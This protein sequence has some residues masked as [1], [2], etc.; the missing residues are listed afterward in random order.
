ML[1]AFIRPVRGEFILAFVL[2][3]LAL[4]LGRFWAFDGG[5]W[6][7]T[8]LILSGLLFANAAKNWT[9]LHALD[10][11]ARRWFSGALT[12]AIIWSIVM[13]AI[14]SAAALIMQRNSPYY[15]WYD[16]FINTEG[17]VKHVDTNGVEYVLLDM[18]LS[19]ASA[20]WTFLISVIAFLAF[21][22]AGIAIGSSTGRWPQLL[23]LGGS[24]VIAL[25]LL[26]GANLYLIWAAE[27]R[28]VNAEIIIPIS[29]ESWQ[30]FLLV[31]VVAAAPIITGWWTIRRSLQHPWN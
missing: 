29:L 18:G 28:A 9:K 7:W 6:T 10:V 26:A 8:G 27:Q 20:A 22:F 3:A 15:A 11:P 12:T 1:T 24:A 31:L 30:R 16:W 23:M 17:P 25:V 13:A 2:I 21:T 14:A 4:G 19:P 5:L